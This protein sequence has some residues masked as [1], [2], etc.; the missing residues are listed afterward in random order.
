M[1]TNKVGGSRRGLSIRLSG[2]LLEPKCPDKRGSTVYST[3][4]LQFNAVL[5]KLCLNLPESQ[6]GETNNNEC[7]QLRYANASRHVLL[8]HAQKVV[9][10]SVYRR[11]N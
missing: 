5:L 8:S 11:R 10:K 9:V 4:H 3:L 7:C 6:I 2:L 1:C